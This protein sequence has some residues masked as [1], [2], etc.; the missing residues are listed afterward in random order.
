MHVMGNTDE[1][2]SLI[3]KSV[4][5]DRNNPPLHS[6]QL[7]TSHSSS[8]YSASDIYEFHKEW[9]RQHASRFYTKGPS[10][11]DPDPRRRLKIGYVSP[12]FNRDIV[13]YFFKPV[14][15]KHNR[16]DFEIFCYS[17]TQI[18]DDYTAYFASNSNWRQI[19]NMSDE[20]VAN[21]I[22]QDKIDILIDLSGHAPNNRLLVFARKPAPIQ[23][24]WLDYFDTTGLETMD[25]L[26][27]DSVSTPYDSSQQFVEKLIRMPH[28]RFCWSPPEFAPKVREPPALSR[29]Y[30]TFGSFNRP[31]KITGDVIHVWARILR[32]IPDSILVLKNRNFSHADTQQHFMNAF[33][34]EGI[35]ADRV[36]MRGASPHEQLLSEYGDIDIAL[37]PFPYNGGATTCDALWM[38]VPVITLAGDRMI[39]RQTASLLSSVGVTDFIAADKDGYVNIAIALSKDVEQLAVV[40]HQLR[41]RL[42]LSPVCDSKTFTSDLERIYREV[43]AD[44][45]TDGNGDAHST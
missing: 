17:N 19:A 40:R 44:W 23:I 16:D 35:T 20:S 2:A 42:A 10:S 36:K 32:E 7:V 21:N 41:Q 30:V 15:D 33:G 39:S 14:F 24:S 1:A 3:L 28:A 9:G 31:E 26:I 38:G 8:R 12:K 13:G 37:D 43:W 34:A 27:T 22:R 45:C 11:S 25:Y 6:H 18:Q 29:G 5:L 4:Q